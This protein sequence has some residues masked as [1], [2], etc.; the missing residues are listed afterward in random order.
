MVISFAFESN[1]DTPIGS[2]M[3]RCVPSSVMAVAAIDAI[4][5]IAPIVF[6]IKKY[7]LSVI[8]ALP[9]VSLYSAL[10]FCVSLA[11]TTGLSVPL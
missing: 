7:F 3:N 9:P 1:N 11:M 10:I 2:V 4:K 6:W 8:F 5:R